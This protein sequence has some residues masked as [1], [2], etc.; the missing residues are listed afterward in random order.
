M[1]FTPFKLQFLRDNPKDDWK[2]VF[3]RVF[4]VVEDGD[5]QSIDRI[6][7]IFRSG[8]N[9]SRTTFFNTKRCVKELYKWL[10]ARGAAP[11][12]CLEYVE[13]INEADITIGSA[14]SKRY[15]RDLDDVLDFVEAAGRIRGF[16]SDDDLLVVKSIIVLTWVGVTR[17]EMCE[18]L[19]RDIPSRGREC[20]L[21]GRKVE[22]S[23]RARNI[24]WTLASTDRY[25]YFPSGAVATRRPSEFLFRTPRSP[26]MNLDGI[27][28]ALVRFNECAEVDLARR[29]DIRSLRNN[30]CCCNL[31]E[32]IGNNPVRL[33]DVSKAFGCDRSA[34]MWYRSVYERWK[35]CFVGGEVV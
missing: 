13:S 6:D 2:D 3:E 24:L 21:A 23:N 20:V 26:K 12:E 33:D 8:D 27:A 15:F 31:Y 7:S 22:L 16:G 25:H 29:V 30:R 34:A 10:V 28:G 32:A 14:V 1:D 18:I 19:K 17:A 4:A 35:K 5:F 9:L 11:K